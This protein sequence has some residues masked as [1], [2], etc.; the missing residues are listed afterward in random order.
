MKKHKPIV[1]SGIQTSGN[2]NLGGYIGAIKNWVKLQNDYDCIF[3]LVDLHT[4]TVRQDPNL[5]HQRLYDF[6]ALYIA[7]GLDPQK[8]IIFCQSHVAAHAQLAWILNCYTYMGELGRMIQFKEKSKK[9]ADNIN[10]GLFAYPVLQAADILLYQTNLVPVGV[11]QKQHIELARDI[12][13]R[14]NGIYGE[15]FTIPE[16]YISPVNQG[17]KIMSLLEPTKKMSKSDTNENNIINLLDSADIVVKKMQ[18][19]V[20]DSDKDIRFHDSKPGVSNL[21]CIYSNV[22][23]KSIEQLEQEYLGKGYG[24]FKNDLAQAIIEFLKPIQK[25]YFE[26][27]QDQMIMD[28][29][30]KTGAERAQ[31]LAQATLNKVHEVIGFIL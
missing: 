24:V 16:P 12:A 4:I 25:Q 11:D 19:A 7:C 30:L 9:Y 27:R 28:A 18:R 21:L 10:I 3:S 1:F 26:L 23:N 31:K 15:I 5:L 20:T 2:L 29:I 13:M 14:F 17:G 22:T 8:S 6:L